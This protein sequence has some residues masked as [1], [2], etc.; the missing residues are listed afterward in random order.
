MQNAKP[1]ALVTGATGFVGNHLV[2]RLV[3]EGWIVHIVSR[4]KSPLSGIL[5]SK[6][7]THHYYDG[8]MASMLNCVMQAKPEIVFHLASIFIAQHDAKDIDALVQSNLLFGTQ[9]LD[10]M[11]INNARYLVNTGTSWQHYNNEDYNPVCLYAA[12]KQAFEAILEYYVQAC[13]FR[14]I[15]LKLFD[16]YGANDR[17]PKLMNQLKEKIL[18]GSSLDM[19]PGEQLID[20]VHIDDVVN[21]YFVAAQRLLTGNVLKKESYGISSRHPV[22]LKELIRIIQKGI[23]KNIDINWGAKPYRFREV[24]MP[25]HSYKQLPGWR[26]VVKINSRKGI[27]SFWKSN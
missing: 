4:H 24:M 26:P 2:C 27:L 1:I 3:R 20:F 18:I 9:L 11:R 12:T 10:A 17:R 15:N 19:S 8:S 5:E 7:I 13:D 14:V 22:S 25:W 21:A 16:T 23:K 6:Q